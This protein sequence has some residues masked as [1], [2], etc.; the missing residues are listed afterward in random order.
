M[1]DLSPTPEAG[2]WEDPAVPVSLTWMQLL[3]DSKTRRKIISF[4]NMAPVQT[5]IDMRKLLE[6]LHGRGITLKNM[7]KRSAIIF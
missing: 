7:S 2:Y 1:E 3:N 5:G 4:T 6:T